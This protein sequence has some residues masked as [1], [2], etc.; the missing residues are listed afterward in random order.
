MMEYLITMVRSSCRVRSYGIQYNSYN[1]N[2]MS[3]KVSDIKK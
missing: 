1:I 2:K 3:K